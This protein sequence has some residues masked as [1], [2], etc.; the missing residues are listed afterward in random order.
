LQVELHRLADRRV[1]LARPAGAATCI[2][3]RFWCRLKM[4]EIFARGQGNDDRDAIDA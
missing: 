3:S 4:S 2:A 1:A